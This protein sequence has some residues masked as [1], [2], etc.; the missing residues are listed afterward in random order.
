MTINSK[1]MITGACMQN[2]KRFCHCG[3]SLEKIALNEQL[4]FFVSLAIY[5]KQTDASVTLRILCSGDNIGC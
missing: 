5:T 4:T 3:M 1:P 2:G